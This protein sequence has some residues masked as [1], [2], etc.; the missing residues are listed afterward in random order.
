MTEREIT[1]RIN[2]QLSAFLDGETT[3]AETHAL[4]DLLHRD[5]QLH[6]VL[7]RH[8]RMQASLRGELH[9]D[10]GSDFA[11]RVMAVI[12]AGN[13]AMHPAKVVDLAP[14]RANPLR[15]TAF[16]LALAASVAAIAV[17]SVQTLLPSTDPAFLTLTTGDTSAAAATARPSAPR[18]ATAAA[19]RSEYWND[20][21]PDA[22]AELNTY[23]LSHNNSAMDH[24]LSGSMG[25]MRVAADDGI[26]FSE[27]G[28]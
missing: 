12:E 22:A 8:Y 18:V 6:A 21:S 10:L 26:E 9:P 1:H 28:R 11:G 27:A 17:L 14:R 24:G 3:A 25:F 7:D 2:E 5:P 15:R 19:S 23:L 13:T 16:G 4:L 20:L